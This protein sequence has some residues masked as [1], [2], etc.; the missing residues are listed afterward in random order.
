MSDFEHPDPDRLRELSGRC[1]SDIQQFLTR[2]PGLADASLADWAAPIVAE[3]MLRGFDSEGVG[4]RIRAEGRVLTTPEKKQMGLPARLKIGDRFAAALQERGRTDIAMT[5]RAIA[6]YPMRQD[7]R[8]RMRQLILDEGT[9]ARMLIY[10]DDGTCAAA[11][12]LTAAILPG[13]RV[14]EFPL[15]DCDKLLCRCG[16]DRFMP[17]HVT[18]PDGIEREAV[19]RERG[20]TLTIE[21][22]PLVI[23]ITPDPPSAT[24]AIPKV[25]RRSHS[26]FARAARI[27]LKVALA[28]FLF[29][30]VLVIIGAIL[31]PPP[32]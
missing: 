31:G 32:R 28:L 30:V 9:P 7:G 23:D 10:D 17:Y 18:M 25:S 26:S 1:R 12:L 4:R 24:P 29:V 22:D 16:F 5:A 19:P 3:C 21:P 11:R 6:H 8:A 15:P 2:H 27:L 20:I 13:D 14:P